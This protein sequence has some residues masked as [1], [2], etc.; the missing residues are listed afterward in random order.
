MFLEIYTS[1]KED[2]IRMLKMN[3][4]NKVCLKISNFTFSFLLSFIIELQ[5]LIPLTASANMQGIN[6]IVCKKS[7]EIKK[8]IPFPYSKTKYNRRNCIT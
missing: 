5:S 4:E 3:I 7:E 1:I 6:N 2:I 8:A